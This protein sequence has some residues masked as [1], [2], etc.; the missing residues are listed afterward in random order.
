MKVLCVS[1][2][3]TPTVK[4]VTCK[5]D[6][7]QVQSYLYKKTNKEVLLPNWD[8]LDIMHKGNIVVFLEKWECE[9]DLYINKKKITRKYTA[10][11]G[12]I[13][14]KG[15]VPEKLRS[16][17]DNDDPDFLMGFYIHD[18]NYACHY[19]SRSD[20]DSLLREMGKYHGAGWYKRNKVYWAVKIAGRSAYKK[21]RMKIEKEKRYSDYK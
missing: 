20:S 12:F 17:V 21:E 7:D 6:Y 16:M 4:Q 1:Y 10:L 9:I 15:S 13:S 2:E 11:P 19:M 14:D 8:S 18:M 3:V 5:S